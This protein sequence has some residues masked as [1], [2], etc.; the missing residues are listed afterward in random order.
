MNSLNSF[1]LTFLA[2]LM[3]GKLIAQ[4]DQGVCISSNSTPPD[5]C[6]MLEVRSTEKGLLLPRMSYAQRELIE[7]DAAALGMWIY[8]TDQTKGFYFYNGINWQCMSCCC[9]AI[10]E[11]WQTIGTSGTLS[12][13]SPIPAFGSCFSSASSSSNQLQIRKTPDGK[14]HIKGEILNTC[15]LQLPCNFLFNLY[16]ISD[17][18]EPNTGSLQINSPLLLNGE[19]VS[20][21][22]VGMCHTMRNGITLTSTQAITVGSLIY[23]NLTYTPN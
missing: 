17:E 13:G 6:A 12:D 5:Q 18:Y 14:V 3:G 8:Q 23:I 20:Y 16:Y 4:I 19:P 9:T 1:I 10:D 11:P 21:L 2:F 22:T 15:D 7:T